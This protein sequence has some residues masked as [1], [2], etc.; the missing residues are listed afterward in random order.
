MPKSVR[1]AC[2]ALLIALLGCS[3]G[4]TDLPD[5]SRD[6][7]VFASGA[8]GNSDIYAMD[9]DGGALVQLTAMPSQDT[10]P[11]PSPDGTRIAFSSVEGPDYI[12]VMNADGSGVTR[13]TG[14]PLGRFPGEAASPSW[15]PDSRKILFTGTLGDN[16]DLFVMNADGS[17]WVNL[18]NDDTVREDVGA[19]SPDGRHIAFV[20]WAGLPALPH[21]HVMDADGHN[22]RQLTSGDVLDFW[23]AW[24]P[25]SRQIVFARESLDGMI[26]RILAL[27]AGG[28]GLRELTHNQARDGEPS[29]SRDGKRLLFTS[30]LG[31]ST[32]TADV[33]TIRGDGLQAVNL[34]G[35]PGLHEVSP[36]WLPVP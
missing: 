16:S 18:T 26:R 17:S 25:D 30:T 33:W 12:S 23:P 31:S 11:A 13:L 8:S 27:G 24:S 14:G 15:S 6:R 2:A 1:C 10:Q 21:I 9:Q 20:R 5:A 28:T 34:T 19:W 32:H 36:R 4:P 29:W 7:I 22:V 35:T 3:D